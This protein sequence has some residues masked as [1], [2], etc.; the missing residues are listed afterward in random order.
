M[1]FAKRGWVLILFCWGC[2]GQASQSPASADE[3]RFFEY[4]LMNAG[5]IDHHSTATAAHETSLVKQFGLSAEESAVIH[6]AGQ[7]L[8]ALLKQLR[9]QAA[10]TTQ[11]KQRLSTADA[12]ALTAL[13]AQRQQMIA[14]LTNQ[15]LNS[16][17][18]PSAARLRAAGSIVGRAVQHRQPGL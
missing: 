7:R 13:M 10:A 6:A 18:A 4:M 9:Q 15:I 11:S 3:L 5:S 2:Y 16:V 1:R 8:N 14:T 12:T 17:S